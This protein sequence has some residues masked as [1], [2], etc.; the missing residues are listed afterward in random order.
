MLAERVEL[1]RV[2]VGEPVGA[3]RDAVRVRRVGEDDEGLA[4]EQR[5]D[6]QVVAQQPSRRRAEEQAEHTAEHDRHRDRE[7]RRPVVREDVALLVMG[8]R[9]EGERVRAEAEERDVAEVEEPGE[10]DD[11][12]EPEP[13]QG[14]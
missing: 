10:P 9:E 8:P 11:D 6:R 12:V 13:E 5:D 2:D 14:V 3:V 7:L 4:E 1:Q